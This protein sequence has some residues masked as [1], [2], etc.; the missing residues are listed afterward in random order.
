MKLCIFPPLVLWHTRLC[1]CG[2]PAHIFT[3]IDCLLVHKGS[4]KIKNSRA[5]KISWQGQNCCF[6]ISWSCPFNASQDVSPC[7]PMC[8]DCMAMQLLCNFF[9]FLFLCWSCCWFV[10]VWASIRRQT[11][12]SG[13]AEVHIRRVSIGPLCLSE[14]IT[15]NTLCVILSW[16]TVHTLFASNSHVDH[17]DIKKALDLVSQVAS[18]INQSMHQV[19]AECTSIDK[20]IIFHIKH[21]PL[22]SHLLLPGVQICLFVYISL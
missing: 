6:Q 7:N 22:M 14:F 12:A 15:L 21:K 5:F 10:G 3:L 9:I 16:L 18:H 8:T 20:I 2:S 19:L 4:W 17:S 11:L 13:V 1:A